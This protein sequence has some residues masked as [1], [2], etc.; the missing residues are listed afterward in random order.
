[1]YILLKLN[2]APETRSDQADKN[3]LEISRLSERH[4]HFVRYEDRSTIR[5]Y[6]PGIFGCH[7]AVTQ[8]F[9]P[10]TLQL[11]LEQNVKR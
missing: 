6:K 8:R 10:D 9:H 11:I 5:Q 1:M 2:V 4:E 3:S 7:Q